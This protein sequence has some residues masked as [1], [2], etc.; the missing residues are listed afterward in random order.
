MKKVLVSACLLGH[1]CRWHGR[2]VPMSKYVLRYRLR[3]TTP[4]SYRLGAAVLQSMYAP[5]MSAHSDGFS[6][7]VK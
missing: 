3:P 5:E 7:Q 2:A 1:P 6:I 4:G